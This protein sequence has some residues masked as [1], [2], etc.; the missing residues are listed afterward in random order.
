MPDSPAR[1][2]AMVS[3][4]A[5]YLQAR[6]HATPEI[7]VDRN[8]AEIHLGSGEGVLV[9]VF[10]CRKRNWSLRSIEVRPRRADHD[11]HRGEMAEAVAAL[12]RPRAAGTRAAAGR[13]RLVAASRRDPPRAAHH[14]DPGMSGTRTP[15]LRAGRSCRVIVTMPGMAGG[16]GGERM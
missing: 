3:H 1:V 11:V 16:Q 10:G 7:S 14:G 15:G 9:A 12:P 5:A 4:C 8:R 6:A 2:P 13:R